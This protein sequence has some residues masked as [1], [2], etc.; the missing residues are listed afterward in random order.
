MFQPI[1]QRYFSYCKNKIQGKYKM[2]KISLIQTLLI[3]ACTSVQAQEVEN[4]NWEGSIGYTNGC[5]YK[6]ITPGIFTFTRETGELTPTRAAT[7]TVVSFNRNN[8][9]VALLDGKLLYENIVTGDSVTEISVNYKQGKIPSK[10]EGDNSGTIVNINPEE[11]SLDNVNLSVITTSTFTIGDTVT[12]DKPEE[13]KD[14]G[15]DLPVYI[16]HSVTCLQ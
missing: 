16:P 7:I 13:L 11:M 8:I 14:I 6:D 15:N 3:L 12:L 1:L 5:S 10:I 2:K 4:L 9:K